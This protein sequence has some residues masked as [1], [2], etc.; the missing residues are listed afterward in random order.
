M[1]PTIIKKGIFSKTILT[2]IQKFF[3]YCILNDKFPFGDGQA[4]RWRCYN[5]SI[6]RIIHYELLELIEHI[7]QKN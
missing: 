3:E 6:S 2:S 4:T 1:N 5:E 7:V